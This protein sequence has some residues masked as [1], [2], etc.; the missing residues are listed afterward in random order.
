MTIILN[1]SDAVIGTYKKYLI[2]VVGYKEVTKE[3][4][5]QELE[6]EL[7]THVFQPLVNS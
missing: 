4:L 6:Y 3:I 7:D 5:I 2:D 1:I